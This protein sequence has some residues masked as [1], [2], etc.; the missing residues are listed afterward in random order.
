MV[1]RPL[2]VCALGRYECD[3]ALSV[4][5]EVEIPA[6]PGIREALLHPRARS[7]RRKRIARHG[8]RRH[9][10]PAAVLHTEEELAPGARPSWYLAAINRNLLFF[11]R[12]WKT[13][14]IHLIAA[15]FVRL[16]G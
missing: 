2:I 5:R 8:V 14:D 4:R 7:F 1:P 15:R 10:D 11:S 3:H 16:V 13:T 9:H 12:P 6:S